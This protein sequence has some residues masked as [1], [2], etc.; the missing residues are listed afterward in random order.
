[1]E[2]R[3]YFLALRRW[4]WLLILAPLLSGAAGYLVS[5]QGAP[6][7]ESSVRVIV[8]QTLQSVNPDY[9]SLVASERL[10]S[11]YVQ[12]AQSRSVAQGVESQLGT[13]GLLSHARIIARPVPETEFLDIAVEAN[14]PQQAADIANAIAAQLILL[15]PSGPQ[16]AEAQ[17]LAEV[18][19]QISTL[20]QQI[21][22]ADADITALKQQVEEIGADKPEV[23]GL[24]SRLQLNQQLQS[25]NRQIL[26]TL[27]S[28]VLGNRSNT[29]SVIEPAIAQ[30]TPIAPYPVQ[31]GILA[32]LVGLMLSLG[33][34]VGLEYL[35]DT[36]KSPDEA[37]DAVGA[38]LLAA[39]IKQPKVTQAPLRLMTKLEPRS[40]AAESFRTLRT[41]MQFSNIDA[42]TRTIIVTSAQPEEGKS[43]VVANLAWTL[44]QSGQR[45]IL[46]DADL[47]K[48]M[49]HRI[50]ELSNEYGLTNLLTNADDA[51]M[52]SLAIRQ[53]T[54]TLWV[55]PSGPQPP[56]PSELLS[57]KRMEMLIW[58]FQQE[59]DWVLFDTPPVLTVTDPLALAPRTDGVLLVAEGKR[60]RRDMLV[61][62]RLALETV[63][64]KIIG[65]AVNKLDQRAEGY[66]AYYTYYYDQRASEASPRRWWTLWSRNKVSVT[67]VSG[68]SHTNGSGIGHHS[69]GN[70][71]DA[72]QIQVA[73]GVL[74]DDRAE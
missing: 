68:K 44:S 40:P 42:K 14:N 59:Y 26:S 16:S 15:S 5:N 10:V 45:V 6:V 30:P 65:I 13:P 36:I 21:N 1:M 55:V 63:G 53:I 7:Y 46:I 39:I 32:G 2:F 69:N 56:N 33:F 24:I 9:G 27:Y 66:Y 74:P 61:R 12:L 52:A 35:D 19:A 34:I 37:V 17:I 51:A 3:R 58:L 31:S 64:A 47:R 60:T 73:D 23:A 71:A 25:E 67:P 57:S 38:P 50:F 70:G 22:E 49:I 29:I 48:P 54:P 4:V 41:N 8:G 72:E 43:T 11:T 28:T 20:K 18:Q 62:S